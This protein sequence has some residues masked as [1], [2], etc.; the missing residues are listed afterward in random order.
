VVYHPEL[1]QRTLQGDPNVIESADW[2]AAW[3]HPTV[4]D[5]QWQELTDR[6]E[7]FSQTWIDASTALPLENALMLTG[8]IGSYAHFTYHLGAV[9]QILLQV[10]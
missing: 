9:P 1:I 5:R 4:D 10:R 7:T 3:R 6:L 2:A 8:S